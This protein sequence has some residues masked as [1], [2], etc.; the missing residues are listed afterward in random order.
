MAEHNLF[1]PP[2]ARNSSAQRFTWGNLTESSAMLAV[3]SLL[4]RQ[5][6]PFLL[7]TPDSQTANQWAVG[8]QFFTKGQSLPI[9]VFPDWE[10]L[11][12]D[13]FSPHTDIVSERL[14]LLAN[15]PHFQRGIMIVAI[16]TLMHRLCPLNYLQNNALIISC[17]DTF[18]R[19]SYRERL[20]K[21]GYQHVAEVKEHGEF[22]VRG[23]IF[24]IFPMGSSLPYRIE[25]LDNTILTIRHFDPETQRSLQKLQHVRLL[26]A[27]EYEL[28][29]TAVAQFRQSWRSRTNADPTDS[30]IYQKISQFQ[31]APGAEYYLPLFFNDTHTLFDYLP[32]HTHLLILEEVKPQA[33]AFWQTIGD[34]YEQLRYDRL[35][36][37]CSPQEVF[38]SPQ[39]YFSLLKSYNRIFLTRSLA[40]PKAGVFNFEHTV[41]P[42]LL[43]NAN[44]QLELHALKNF[45]EES[46]ESNR[47]IIFCVESAGRQEN[48]E[49]LLAQVP[50]YPARYNSW[51]DCLATPSAHS[52]LISP[53]E[54]GFLLKDP[55]LAVI[56]ETDLL[57]QRIHQGSQKKVKD[58][59]SAIRN[60]VELQIGDPIVH[61]EHGVGRYLGLQTLTAGGYEAEYLTLQYA[62]GDIVYVPI[63]SLHL[64][65]RY[66]GISHDDIPLQKLGSKQWEKIKN[67][68]LKR[69]WDVAAELLAIHEQRATAQGFAY[70]IPELEYQQFVKSFPFEET[71]DQRT[72]IV[73]VLKDMS[74]PKGMDRVICGDVGFGKTEI[75]MRAAF[76]AVQNHK[77][78]AVL[79]PTT[80]LAEQHLHNFRDRFAGWPIHIAA[81]S[82]LR[83]ATDMRQILEEVATGKIDILI[84]TH[85]LLDPAIR[86]KTLGLLIID[87]EHRFGVRQ[88]EKLKALRAELDILTLT[89]T[90]IPRTLNMAL[91]GVR[92]LSIIATP[93]AKRL[94]IKT[95][96][97][98]FDTVLIREAILREIM[99]GGQVY[100]LH[101][102]VSSIHG[103]E[104]KLKKSVPEARFGIAHGQMRERELERIMSDFYHQKF[105]VLICSTIIESGIDIPTANTII[106]NNADCFGMAQLHQLRGR[107]G[108]S[109]HQAYAYLLV[110]SQERLSEHSQKR[111]A[112]IVQFDQLGIGFNLA[113]M[114]LEI[115]GAGEL[116]GANQSGHIQALGFSLY[117]HLLSEAVSA[118]KQGKSTNPDILFH[119]EFEIDLGISALFPEQYVP[120]VE[121][122]LTLYKRLATLNSVK[123][124]DHF[125][126][127]L[128]D[129]FGIL[130]KP[131]KAL[132]SY[133][134][135]RCLSQPL[136]IIKITASTQYIHIYFSDQPALDP[137][138]LIYL[139]TIDN[140]KYQLLPE[141]FRITM[142]TEG[143]MK[144]LE[145][146]WDVLQKLQ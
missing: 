31:V 115:R 23:S 108:R 117:M 5:A 18:D 58:P 86:F 11:P 15:A 41:L 142:Q 106:I 78:V 37:L 48:I 72:A 116:L 22:A 136:G 146:V 36:P 62:E 3:S 2:F 65:N 50:V 127:E 28:S 60:L 57:G 132:L 92:D 103:M 90:P 44:N 129:R 133:A 141:Q 47:S 135:M 143:G 7:I 54:T 29:E 121:I 33:D 52:I 137:Q 96:I 85:K 39:D 25:L 70:Q 81:I 6:F 111:L 123:Q 1:N 53:V 46:S 34:R 45:I 140:K 98:D 120:E 89:A 73:A 27:R 12:Y 38:L 97:H 95:F 91:S 43:I 118:L 102:E 10:T 51:A 109:H 67:Q 32:L 55:P 71:P 63:T 100:F 59:Q 14:A 131:A 126:E 17:G 144:K 77:Q 75:A 112:A 79:A 122:R 30:L 104:N 128:T 99:R 105:N 82:R 40:Q 93:P 21:S 13:H 101:N 107:V 20:I 9:E 4:R 74:E 16:N 19:T 139:I 42:E 83:S 138:K 49:K 94:S 124:I 76:I 134:K 26:P 8:L 88:K 130:P 24:D 56:T 68:A 119:K 69:V 113:S 80:L 114:D 145:A 125:Q 87:E 35:R 64:I 66:A 61:I 110:P 84:G